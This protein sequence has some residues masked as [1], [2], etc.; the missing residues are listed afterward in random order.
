MP[1]WALDLENETWECFLESM[2]LG[3]FF[4]RVAVMLF[5]GE[6]EDEFRAW[7]SRD[8][9]SELITVLGAIVWFRL[10]PLN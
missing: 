8:Y 4:P 2:C 1:S 6:S 10:L 5:F 3:V 9:S 7:T